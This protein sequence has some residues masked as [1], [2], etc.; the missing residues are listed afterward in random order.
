MFDYPFDHAWWTGCIL[1]GGKLHTYRIVVHYIWNILLKKDKYMNIYT[2]YLLVLWKL[3]KNI[4]KKK[5]YK[6]IFNFANNTLQL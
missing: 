4:C 1:L 3:I 6:I 5:I 2:I